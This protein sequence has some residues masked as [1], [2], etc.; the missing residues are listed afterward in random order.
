MRAALTRMHVVAAA[1]FAGLAA[2]DQ[3]IDRSAGDRTNVATVAVSQT[4]NAPDDG[5]VAIAD[6]MCL[7]PVALSAEPVGTDAIWK[8]YSH[9]SICD[10]DPER[11]GRYLDMLVE[12]NDPVAIHS[13]SVLLEKRDPE[14]SERLRRRAEALGYRPVREWTTCETSRP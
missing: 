1:L 13:K 10:Y 3:A 4:L 2:C 5:A 9:W 12:R 8:R 6:G 11:A 14:E 7:D